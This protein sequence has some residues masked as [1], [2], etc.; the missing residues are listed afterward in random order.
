[1]FIGFD[2]CSEVA[3]L[4]LF[5]V[6]SFPIQV[7][8]REFLPESV[9]VKGQVCVMAKSLQPCVTS[10]RWP[11]VVLWTGRNVSVDVQRLAWD[12]FYDPISC[13]KKFP[14]LNEQKKKTEEILTLV[15]KTNTDG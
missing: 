8:T 4:C 6:L 14:D 1:M 12:A 10:D 2:Q 11:L 9:C 13:R 5:A 3:L 7:C 15:K